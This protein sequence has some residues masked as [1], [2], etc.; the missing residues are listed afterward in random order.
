V[1]TVLLPGVVGSTA[2]GLA[3]PHS[4]MAQSNGAGRFAWLLRARDEMLET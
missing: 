4:D 3:G 2:Y 1:T